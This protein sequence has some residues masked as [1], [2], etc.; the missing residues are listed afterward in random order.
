M[1]VSHST[2]GLASLQRDLFVF[3]LAC[4]MPGLGAVSALNAFK[5]YG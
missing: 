4:Q 1:Y 5:V 2:A 3:W